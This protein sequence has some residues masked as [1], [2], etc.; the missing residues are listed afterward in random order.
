[1]GDL[2]SWGRWG[3][4][5]GLAL[6][7]GCA[8][9]VV[10]AQTPLNADGTLSVSGF[11]TL[12]LTHIDAPPG[13]GFRR[14]SGL[15]GKTAG[16]TADVDSRVGVQ[17]NYTPDPRFEWVT[18][19]MA[20]PR[21]RF[22]PDDEIL[23]WAFAAVRPTPQLQFRLGRL[24]SDLMLM[25]TYRNVGF[26]YA[27]VRPPVEVYGLVPSVVDGA[28]VAQVWP[29]EQ[30]RWR[31]ALMLGQARAGQYAAGGPLRLRDM[32]WVTLSYETS[33]LMVRTA[34]CSGRFSN[35]AQELQP[36]IDSLSRVAAL[37]LPQVAGEAATLADALTT[38]G[39]RLGY[40]TLS[41]KQEAGLW[42]VQGEGMRVTG[43]SQGRLYGG[44]LQ[45]GRRFDDV[46]L[47]S[48]TSQVKSTL[49]LALQPDWQATLTP[50]IGASAAAQ[51]QQL[52]SATATGLAAGGTDQRTFS[53]GAAW[54]VDPRLMLKLQ[55][56]RV[57]AA[58]RGGAYWSP[59]GLQG[60]QANVLSLSADFVW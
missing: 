35:N 33:G 17:L 49:A 28:D 21:T 8:A 27:T 60:V 14:E 46:T 47:F 12:G 56:D 20:V 26:A 9:A 15:A 59:R 53:V 51:A 22:T 58:A 18:Q 13:W 29:T 3:R 54:A 52:A 19:L 38:A 1:M 10:A 34:W 6:V 32:G 24:S 7:L 16:W 40:V 48:Q 50:V 41:V 11:G 25:S 5:G 31:A 43:L 37:P 39:R 57:R 44:Y 4:R 42:Q 2:C 30:G 45:V 55:W 36:A 23:R